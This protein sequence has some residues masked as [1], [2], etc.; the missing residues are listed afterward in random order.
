MSNASN[1]YKSI[2][3]GSMLFGGVQVFSILIN[4]IRGK[5]IA[6]LLGPEGMGISSLLSVSANTIQQFSGLGLN[7]SSIK[8]LSETGENNNVLQVQ[9]VVVTIRRL[10]L[11]TALIGSLF[12]MFF[13]SWLSEWTF[14]NAAYKWHFVFLSLMIF[15]TTLSNGELSIL[16]GLHAIK[17]MAFA[18]VI[19]SSIGLFIGIPLYY[20]CGYDGIVPAMIVLSLATF[21]FYRYHSYHLVKIPNFKLNWREM[22]PLAKRMIS[23]GI[24]MM[25]ATLL[26]TLTNYMV[27]TFIGRTGSLNDVGLFQAAHSITN[28]YIG[29]VFTAMGMDFFPRLSAVSSD[30]Q[31]IRELVNQQTEIV[32]LISIPLAI[33]LIITAPLLIEILLTDQFFTLIPVIRWMGLGIAFKAIAFPMGYISFA[34]G[35]KKTFFWLEGIWGNLLMLC[36]NITF[37]YYWGIYGLGVS[38]A[39]LYIISCLL[40]K[41]LTFRL[42]HF[43]H[44]SQTILLSVKA[45]LLLIICFGISFVNYVYI[46][47]GGMII[48][49]VIAISFSVFEL[50]KRTNF[51][52]KIINHKNK[53]I[54]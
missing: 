41:M 20:F 38:F 14:G 39:I 46:S 42:Y 11:L 26:G 18:S 49:G 7:L 1:S 36:L 8:E 44:N 45:L 21:S 15:F 30:E 37:Y 6:L 33:L 4:L 23:L 40:Y 52:D 54:I 3:K 29:L 51:L 48:I 16:Q 10:L 13:C 9:T 12:S 34:K 50:N 53:S 32:I 27:N 19:G 35:D 25:I 31:K 24:I 47:Y 2:L 28:Q 43:T 22:F 17:K 5:L